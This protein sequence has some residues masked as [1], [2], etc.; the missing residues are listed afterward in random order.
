MPSIIFVNPP[1]TTRDRYGVKF[2]SGGETPPLGLASLAAVTRG[3][4]LKTE[5]VDASALKLSIEE[6][7]NNILEKNP[8]YVG[9]TAVT[10]SVS[11]AAKIAELIRRENS[12][13][14]FLIGGSHFTALPEETL[15]RFAIFDLGCIGEAESTIVDLI[16]ALENKDD[17]KQVKGLLIKNNEDLLF[18]GPRKRIKDLDELPF[19]AWD[20]LPNL[21]KYYCPP[22]HTLKKIPAG[23]IVSSRGCPG[24]CIFCDR[25][26]F[27]NIGTYYSAEY[28]LKM[29]KDLYYNYGIREIQFRDDNFTA[30]RKRL[31]EFCNLLAREGLDLVWSISGRV[32]MVN[33]EILDILKKAGCW[34]IWYGIE[35]GSQRILDI[36][37]KR[38]NIQMIKDAVE[39]TAKAGIHSCG[40]F[41]IGHP[42][43]T[44]EDIEK[45]IKFATSMPVSEAHF[46]LMTPFPGSELYKRAEEFGSFENNWDKMTGW[47]PLFVPYTLTTEDIRK[48]SNKAFRKFYFRPKVV[49][50][51]IKKIRSFKHLLIY[52]SGFLALMD[53]FILNFIENK[54]KR[55]L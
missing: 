13:I 52:F 40:F 6:T 9:F 12:K 44:K 47:I 39:S 55:R 49:F 23:L 19:P 3:M 27:G 17:L 29:V 15:K 33:P 24:K 20:L 28:L 51:Y 1:L 41:I 37:K 4:R 42:T 54:K 53:Y 14:I 22:V 35:S 10:I 11:K 25:C 8:D 26:V 21:A 2:Q 30:F 31:V 38:T 7:A 16:N 18:T 46:S 45:T 48:Y 36:I 32:D 43:E 34:Q 50:E 5:I